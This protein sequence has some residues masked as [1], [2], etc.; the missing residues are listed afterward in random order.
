M[1]FNSLQTKNTRKMEKGEELL[2][3]VYCPRVVAGKKAILAGV[4]G[5]STQTRVILVD[6]TD[7]LDELENLRVIPSIYSTIEGTDELVAKSDVLYDVLDS[8][9]TNTI[10]APNNI[11]DKVRVVRGTKLV[12]AN[13]GSIKLNSSIQ[14][15]DSPVFYVNII[16]AIAVGLVTKYPD[17][18]CEEYDVYAGI[19]LPPDNLVSTKNKQ[20]FIDR[21]SGTFIWENKDLGVKLTINIKGVSVQT[22]PEANIKA[23][24]AEES[25]VP[26]LVFCL[27]G[28]GAT[29]GTEILRN[30]LSVTSAARTFEYGGTH[31]Q[32]LLGQEYVEAE[33]GRMPAQSQLKEALETGVIKVGRETKDVV[34][35]IVTAKTSLANRI[36]AD[37]NDKVFDG[38]DNITIDQLHY[39]FFTGQLFEGGKFEKPEVPVPGVKYIPSYSLMT[40]I[41]EKLKTLAPSTEFK[42]ISENLIPKGNFLNALND[43]MGYVFPQE[44]EVEET[45]ETPA[46][47]EVAASVEEEIVAQD[48]Q[49]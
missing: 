9:I 26:E 33:G 5:G 43:Y 38:Q 30:G 41:V 35:H 12:D 37:I 8:N 31:L 27:E 17:T 29:L 11:F 45:E 15:I 19:S 48:S 42:R 23:Y 28:G 32:K 49:V 13:K 1:K 40:P 6:S 16:D 44:E 18:L 3:K 22:E 25:E 2:G 34:S 14:K 39:F 10:A 20:K 24:F 4:D 36:V 7:D 46:L 47:N 21:I